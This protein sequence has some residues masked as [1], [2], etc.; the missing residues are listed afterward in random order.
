MENIVVH[1]IVRTKLL[2]TEEIINFD[3]MV[4]GARQ[5]QLVTTE[6][7]NEEKQQEVLYRMSS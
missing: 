4:Q 5:Y 1:K 6:P 7:Y 2:V 3:G